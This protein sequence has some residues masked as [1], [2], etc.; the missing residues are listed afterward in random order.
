MTL[1]SGLITIQLKTWKYLDIESKLEEGLRFVTSKT[2]PTPLLIHATL[3][4]DCNVYMMRNLII[5]FGK[6]KTSRVV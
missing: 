1:K 2:F 3:T 4:S 6:K 5:Y